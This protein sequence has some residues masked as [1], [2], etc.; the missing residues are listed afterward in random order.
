MTQSIFTDMAGV[1][2]DKKVLIT[3]G[4]G[5]IGSNL[6]LQLVKLGAKVTLIDSMAPDYGGNLFN[7]KPIRDRVQIS[8]SDVRDSHSLE[9]LV[10]DQQFLF[11]LAG[12]IS[13]I[14]SMTD[15][16][17]DLDINTRAQVSILETCRKF[18]P[19]V[20]IVFAGTRQIY[21]KPRYL[22]VDENH[23]IQPIDVNGI[24]TVAGEWY[25]MLYHNVY[26]MNTVSLRLTNTYGPRQLI[27][28]NRQGFIGVFIRQIIQNERIRIYGDGK[29]IRDLNYVDDVVQALLLAGATEECLG[30]VF[31]LGGQEPINLL[32]LVKL[33]IELNGS[34]E[35]ELVPFPSDQKRIDIGSYYGDYRKFAQLTGWQPNVSLKAGFGEMLTYYRTHLAKYLEPIEERA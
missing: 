26:S 31:N 5:F 1:Y 16:L 9:S 27:K 34:G 11:N 22:P 12:Q 33:L 19:S 25:H 18:N 21:G 13:H 29:Q 23:P 4:L 28:H 30:Q 24:N 35:F 7:I 15:P 6:A 2:R 10:K 14:D 3:G 32:N 17:T 8:F 20:R